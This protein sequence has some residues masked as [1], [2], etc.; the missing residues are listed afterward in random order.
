[1]DDRDWHRNVEGMSLGKGESVKGTS[2]TSGCSA[3]GPPL[4]HL[5]PVLG[6]ISG[7]MEAMAEFSRPEV[8]GRSER[9]WKRADDCH[10]PKSAPLLKYPGGVVSPRTPTPFP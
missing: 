2:S 4:T 6:H 8:W 1:M 3:P 7:P 5:M 10:T 9:R